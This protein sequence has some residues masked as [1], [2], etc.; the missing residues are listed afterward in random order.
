MRIGR[1]ARALA[2]RTATSFH[3]RVAESRNR[4]VPF[5][6]HKRRRGFIPFP[7]A[8]ASRFS[9]TLAFPKPTSSCGTYLQPSTVPYPTFQRDKGSYGAL[10]QIGGRDAL[11]TIEWILTEF[12]DALWQDANREDLVD[13]SRSCRG[14]PIRKS[15]VQ[16]VSGSNAAAIS[17]SPGVTRNSRSPTALPVGPTGRTRNA[18]TRRGIPEALPWGRDQTGHSSSPLTRIGF[19][20]GSQRFGVAEGNRSA[21]GR[22]RMAGAGLCAS[23]LCGESVSRRRTNARIIENPVRSGT[24]LPCVSTV[25]SSA[26]LMTNSS[27]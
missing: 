27:F 17:F 10:P 22:K 19:A 24:Q 14:Q 20:G 26:D 4:A 2:R 15:L 13:C 18:K 11:V 23:S 12:G 5:V 8:A 3:C 9:G 7:S 1:D 16:T 21:N 6:S 25:V